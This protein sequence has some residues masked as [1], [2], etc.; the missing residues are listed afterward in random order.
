MWLNKSKKK[1]YGERLKKAF[2]TELEKEVKNVLKILPLD[3][4]RI[5]L[6]DGQIHKVDNLI[7]SSEYEVR[8]NSE[9]LIIPYRL[10]FNEPEEEDEKKLNQIEN[11][12]M[13]CIYLRHHN[14]YL[15]EKRLKN[16]LNSKNKF[17][18]PFLIQLLGEYVLEIVEILDKHIIESNLNLYQE[19]VEE[20]PKYWQKTESRM[21]SYWDTYYRYK[22]PKLKEYIG[23]KLVK[24]IKRKR[25]P[26]NA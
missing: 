3:N 16:L 8:L 6:N 11:E 20:N 12:I 23:Y 19:F 25:T 22:S 15:R 17:V 9:N 21:V 4:Q 24:K 7:H 10:Y 18:I 14:G 5:K 1:K 13:N 2:P 26:N